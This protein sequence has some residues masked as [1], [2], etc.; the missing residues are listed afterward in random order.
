MRVLGRDDGQCAASSMWSRSAADTL[1]CY[2]KQQCQTGRSSSLKS[3]RPLMVYEASSRIKAAPRAIRWSRPSTCI[4]PT[5]AKPG[6][7]RMR[8]SAR[9]YI[10]TAKMVELLLPHGTCTR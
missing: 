9:S 7:F 5:A 8:P 6:G 10:G 2:L 3:D 4:V 1:G